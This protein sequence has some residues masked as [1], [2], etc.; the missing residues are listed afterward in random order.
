MPLGIRQRLFSHHN[1]GFLI[2]CEDRPA[3]GLPCMTHH[4]IKSI[5]R[6]LMVW[7]GCL[8]VTCGPLGFLQFI[9]WATMLAN[10][11]LE[12]GLARGIADTF[13]GE[14]PCA[15]C[16]KIAESAPDQGRKPEAPHPERTAP[17]IQLPQHWQ[18]AISLRL[19]PPPARD[20]ARLRGKTGTGEMLISALPSGPDTPPPRLAVFST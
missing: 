13:S 12:D 15:M 11:S 8:H 20:L 5:A 17:A 1:N 18:P 7:L 9:A 4:A 19:D 2:A 16:L 3:S 14:R 10:Y 6:H